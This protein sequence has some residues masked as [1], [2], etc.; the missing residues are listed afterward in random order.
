MIDFD[1][2][3]D[4][5]DSLVSEINGLFNTER[6]IDRSVEQWRWEFSRAP[7]GGTHA[8]VASEGGRVVGFELLVPLDLKW[9]GQVV[10]SAKSEDSQIATSHRGKGVYKKLYDLV[11]RIA[12]ERGIAA[13]WGY[14]KSFGIYERLSFDVSVPLESYA[15]DFHG[16]GA[17]GAVASAYQR[18]VT[19]LASLGLRHVVPR[20]VSPEEYGTLGELCYDGA[21]DL[22]KCENFLRWRIADHPYSPHAI[23]RHPDARF[24]EIVSVGYDHGGK[25]MEI[26]DLATEGRGAGLELLAGLI[27]AWPGY[28]AIVR[29]TSGHPRRTE[30]A[31]LLRR[32]GFFPLPARG[33][34][35]I[36]KRYGRALED[37]PFAAN[38]LWTEGKVARE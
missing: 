16:G 23:Y 29:L 12:L 27:A 4:P 26:A 9:K 25:V 15:Y 36:V 20:P 21:A 37:A 8:F 33:S 1:F 30:T 2:V 28:T 5:D 10:R 6:G 34:H 19:P 14:T 31:R 11:D 24:R 22:V 7:G 13:I 18:V 3:D 17:L 38:G 35:F 32:L